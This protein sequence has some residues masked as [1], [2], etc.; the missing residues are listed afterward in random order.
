MTELTDTRDYWDAQSATFDAQPYHG[1]LD[2]AVRAAWAQLLL[3]LMPPR[4][5]PSSTL[6]AGPAASP[7]SWLRHRAEA[8]VRELTDPILW[9]HPIDDE[10]YLVMSRS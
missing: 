6:G 8:T 4:R 9:G 5:H 10:R 7:Y 1:L 3:P 2:P